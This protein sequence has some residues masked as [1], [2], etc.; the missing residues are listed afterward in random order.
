MMYGSAGSPNRRPN[1]NNRPNVNKPNTLTTAE[2]L[3]IALAKLPC[4]IPAEAPARTMRAVTAALMQSSAAQKTT[5][6]AARIEVPIEKSSED[7]AVLNVQ[8]ICSSARLPASQRVRGCAVRWEGAQKASSSMTRTVCKRFPS[9]PTE[10]PV[11]S[12]PVVEAA[13]TAAPYRELCRVFH[14]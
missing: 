9:N 14:P 2:R 4:D 11:H 5:E 1:V 6:M 10:A 7:A 12:P 8:R 13:P 3:C